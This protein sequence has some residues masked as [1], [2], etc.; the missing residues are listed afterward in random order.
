MANSKRK[1]VRP[2]FRYFFINNELNQVLRKNRAEDLIVAWNFNQHR[3]MAYSWTDVNNNMQR[4]YQLREVANIFNR[5]PLTVH[6]WI[7]NGDIARPT[8]T[9]SLT[10]RNFQGFYYFSEDDIR[11]VHDYLCGVTMGRPRKDG[12][13][14]NNRMPTRAEL[15]AILRRETILYV[16]DDTGDYV[17]VW[18]QPEWK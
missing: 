15:E 6:R 2:K 12:G 16:K 17:P 10:G 13:V 14:T 3:R 5:H 18:K 1:S 8:K 11:A 7:R 4:A 9:Y